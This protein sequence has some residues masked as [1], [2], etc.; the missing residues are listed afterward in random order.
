MNNVVERIADMILGEDF[1]N[2]TLSI[3]T[4]E[5]AIEI[6]YHEAGHFVVK[7][8]LDLSYMM[9]TFCI[10]ILPN[11]KALGANWYTYNGKTPQN[12]KTY[13]DMIAALLGGK[14]ATN[15]IGLNSTVCADD[16]NRAYDIAY[17]YVTKYKSNKNKEEQIIDTIVEIG[18]AVQQLLLDNKEKLEIIANALLWR[19]ILLKNEL[20]DLYD[21]TISIEDLEPLE[22]D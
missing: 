7:Q 22:L 2:G 16:F 4:G 9:D 17:K 21:G 5:E 3:P 15:I 1:M 11:N 10:T 13:R 20:K 6:A 8:V 14:M 18:T 19:K 12:A